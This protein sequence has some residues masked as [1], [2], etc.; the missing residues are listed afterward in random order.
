MAGL[1]MTA[2]SPRLCSPIHLLVRDGVNNVANHRLAYGHRLWVKGQLLA[3]AGHVVD[4][5]RVHNDVTNRLSS[6]CY[7]DWAGSGWHKMHSVFDLQALDDTLPQCESV[8]ELSPGAGPA[9]EAA[10]GVAH[11]VGCVSAGEANQWMVQN[12]I[13]GNS[14]QQLRMLAMGEFCQGVHWPVIIPILIHVVFA[15]R[16]CEEA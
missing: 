12:S 6:G 10:V 5:C 14:F 15:L 4:G 16:C 1:A 2:V 7:V 9:P 13:W 8:Q 3:Q 11:R